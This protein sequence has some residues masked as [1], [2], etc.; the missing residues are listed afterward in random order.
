MFPVD[1]VFVVATSIAPAAAAPFSNGVLRRRGFLSLRFGSVLPVPPL[2]GRRLMLAISCL[3]GLDL[4]CRA[5]AISCKWSAWTPLKALSFRFR[6]FM[7]LSPAARTAGAGSFPGRKKA[8]T[9]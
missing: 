7:G 2:L 5:L 9:K 8:F 4:H 6:D 3:H 1:F